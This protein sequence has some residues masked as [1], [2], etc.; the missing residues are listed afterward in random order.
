[1]LPA[2]K[3]THEHILHNKTKTDISASLVYKKKPDVEGSQPLPNYVTI[4]F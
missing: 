1:M 3:I 4:L 2:Y